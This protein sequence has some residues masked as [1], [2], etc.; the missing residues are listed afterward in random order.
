MVNNDILNGDGFDSYPNFAQQ[1]KNNDDEKQ[2][3]PKL[4]KVNGKW[5]CRCPKYTGFGF[6]F[7]TAWID[8]RI[9]AVGKL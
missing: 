3:K 5:L 7:K 4:T 6:S 9:K 2:M 8:W 1:T